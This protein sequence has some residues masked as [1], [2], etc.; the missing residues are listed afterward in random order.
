MCRYQVIQFAC[1]HT[2]ESVQFCKLQRQQA[3]LSFRLRTVSLACIEKPP[4]TYSGLSCG[5]LG[6]NC[7]HAASGVAMEHTH[8]EFEETS[9][10]EHS[11]LDRTVDR[12]PVVDSTVSMALVG[13]LLRNV[14]KSPQIWRDIE[15]ISTQTVAKDSSSVDHES[16]LD[17]DTSTEDVCSPSFSDFQAQFVQSPLDFMSIDAMDSDQDYRDDWLVATD[18]ASHA[19]H[20]PFKNQTADHIPTPAS[21]LVDSQP[22]STILPPVSNFA[23]SPKGTS[24]R[25]TPATG[26]RR[27]ARIQQK[28]N[29][30]SNIGHR[31]DS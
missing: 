8:L 17:Q 4:P 30:S 23:L 21:L 29:R 7:S 20:T 2:K 18:L 1:G 13:G 9:Q 24:A 16:A 3:K 11:M 6:L 19:D 15:A 25:R 14:H 28:V 31:N 12:S 10:M 5:S 27:S 26:T 22:T